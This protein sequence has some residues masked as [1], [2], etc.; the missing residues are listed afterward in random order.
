M[1][2]RGQFPVEHRENLRL[3]RMKNHVVHP[4]IAMD[5]GGLFTRRDVVRQPLDQIL[6]RLDALVS[7]ARYCLVQRLIWRAI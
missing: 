1:A 4:V 6:H 5:D 3:P 7:E 2:E